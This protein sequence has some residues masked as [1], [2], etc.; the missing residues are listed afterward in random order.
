MNTGDALLPMWSSGADEG[1]FYFLD[2][3]Y[4]PSGEKAVMSSTIKGRRRGQRVS[5]DRGGRRISRVSKL[6][7]T[8]MSVER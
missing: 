6:G 2:L 8:L 4:S 7:N 3:H 1:S 5:S